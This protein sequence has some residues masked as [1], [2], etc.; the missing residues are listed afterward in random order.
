[1]FALGALTAYYIVLP[2]AIRFLVGFE[3]TGEGD[4]LPIEL[5]AR[6]QQFVSLVMLFV[7]SFGVC[8][9]L[10]VLM[11]LLARAGIVTSADLAAK[12][13]YAI[14]AVFIA[15]AVL[16]PPDPVSQLALALP[17]ILLYEISIYLARL[18]ENRRRASEERRREDIMDGPE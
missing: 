10:P 4:A 17:L 11:V 7:M 12:R 5:E 16:T 8:F 9:E 18:A 3:T 1:M 13:R 15:A 6:V 14:V 2:L